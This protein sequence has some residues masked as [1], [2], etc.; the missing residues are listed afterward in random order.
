ME[1]LKCKRCGVVFDYPKIQST[2]D[3][4]TLELELED[5]IQF[6][7][8]QRPSMGTEV[9]NNTLTDIRGVVIPNEGS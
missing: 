6:S 4:C 1:Y 2:C 9:K 3:N 7:F 5:G 8:Y